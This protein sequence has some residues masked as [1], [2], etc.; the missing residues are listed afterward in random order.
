MTLAEI[1]G[2]E[3]VLA[4][5][6]PSYEYRSSQLEMAEAVLEA[7]QNQHHLCV[8]AGTGTGKTL[9]YLI[10]A[11]FSRKRVIVSTATKNLQEQLF[12]RTSRLSGSICF[13][14]FPPPT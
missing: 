13:P 10:P 3:G 5:C 1:F 8:E 9:A 14:S 6:L 12:S 11:L 4:S 7:I 2:P